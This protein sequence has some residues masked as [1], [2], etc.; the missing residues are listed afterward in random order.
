[1]Q[2]T[3][4]QIRE[5]YDR[6]YVKIPGAISKAMVDTARQARQ[7]LNRHPGA[8]WR[9]HVQT[10]RGAILPR[11]KWQL[12]NNG[13]VQRQPGRLPRRISHGRGQFAKT[14]QRRAGR[15]AVSHSNRRRPTR[16]AWPSRRH[17]HRHKWH[18]KRRIPPRIHLPL[19]SSIWPMYP[20]PTAA[21]SPSGRVLIASL[22]T[23]SNAKASKYSLTAPHA[24]TCPKART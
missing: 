20:N 11:L 2:L 23:T 16:T 15:P 17:G 3:P 21:T 8:K 14:H 10:S 24:L 5:F 19:P 18:A 22:K 6:G 7:P 12:R 4:E 13:P 9:R 1:M